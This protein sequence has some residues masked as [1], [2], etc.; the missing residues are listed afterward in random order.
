VL[1]STMCSLGLGR[2]DRRTQ[3][4]REVPL[5]RRSA[6]ASAEAERH[7]LDRVPGNSYVAEGMV[8]SLA[9][10]MTNAIAHQMRIARRPSMTP[11]DRVAGPAG[12][13]RGSSVVFVP[14]GLITE[15]A[16]L[17]TQPDV[18]ST[19]LRGDYCVCA[20]PEAPRMR[21]ARCFSARTKRANTSGVILSG[22]IP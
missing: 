4:A 21:I 8:G 16:A 13:A 17:V 12:L 7:L 22:S 18:A 14:P 15:E 19:E 5:G 20:L 10:P 11:G 2:G 3:G 9:R 1:S 6:Y